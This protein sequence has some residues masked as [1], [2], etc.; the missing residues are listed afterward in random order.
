MSEDTKK[1]EGSEEQ[2]RRRGSVPA[3][4]RPRLKEALRRE[5]QMAATRRTL[6]DAAAASMLR[7]GVG[8]GL[9]DGSVG[10]SPCWCWVLVLVLDAARKPINTSG[11]QLGQLDC[12]ECATGDSTILCP[13]HWPALACS[14]ICSVS[15]VWW[16]G[17]TGR[18]KSAAGG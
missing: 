4:R 7:L 12:S 1:E 3:R 13:N 6:A 5:P 18:S 15:I 11:T 10:R 17:S 14:T 2:G 16:H 8:A 9:E